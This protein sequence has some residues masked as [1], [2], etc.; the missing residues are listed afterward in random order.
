MTIGKGRGILFKHTSEMRTFAYQSSLMA[1][2]VTALREIGE[3]NATEQQK[4]VIKKHLENASEKDFSHDI[5]LVPVW[6]RK[7]I[8]LLKNLNK[9]LRQAHVLHADSLGE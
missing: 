3:S 7:G 4:A 5:T 1:L 6:V 9:A 8:E 2:I